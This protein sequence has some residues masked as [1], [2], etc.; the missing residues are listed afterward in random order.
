MKDEKGYLIIYK[1]DDGKISKVYS[2]YLEV[3]G[4]L[5]YFKSDNNQ[6]IIPSNRLLKI[7]EKIK[8]ETDEAK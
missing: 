6:I 8:G 5:I 1:D 7:K 3:K 4:N 2:S